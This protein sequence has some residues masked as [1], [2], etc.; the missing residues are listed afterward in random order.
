MYAR[1]FST[2]TVFKVRY[3]TS[4]WERL[5][6]LANGNNYYTVAILPLVILCILLQGTMPHLRLCCRTEEG[7]MFR[8]TTREN[9]DC[10][11]NNLC[12]VKYFFIIMKMH[13]IRHIAQ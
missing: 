13:T 7:K 5:P 10:Q 12:I 11:K 8:E 6:M 3:T 1:V 4:V 9:S 2:N